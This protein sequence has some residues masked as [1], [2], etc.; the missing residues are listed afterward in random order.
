MNN[1][2]LTAVLAVKYGLHKVGKCHNYT[3][4]ADVLKKIGTLEAYKKYT[5]SQEASTS[6]SDSTAVED[7]DQSEF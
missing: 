2:T 4:P 5:T 7:W 6:T 3:L 1:E